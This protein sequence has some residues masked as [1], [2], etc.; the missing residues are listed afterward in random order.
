MQEQSSGRDKEEKEYRAIQ[1]LPWRPLAGFSDRTKS[2]FEGDR[3]IGATPAD[4]LVIPRM[5][6]LG[7][8]EG[9]GE[10]KKGALKWKGWKR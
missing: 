9:K 10:I 2:L 3:R 6:G 8:C 4:W 5:G 1:A 7:N